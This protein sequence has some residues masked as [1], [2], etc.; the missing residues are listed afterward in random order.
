MKE[1]SVQKAFKMVTSRKDNKTSIKLPY[2]IKMRDDRKEKKINKFSLK[3]LFNAISLVNLKHPETEDCPEPIDTKLIES[4]YIFG[5]AVNPRYEKI[6]KKFAFGLYSYETERMVIPNDL[7]IICFMSEAYDVRHI[8]SMTTWEM[9]ISSSYGD[10]DERIYGNF[11]V[12][13]VPSSLVYYRYE[14]NK[15]FLENIKNDGVCIMGKNLLEAKRYAEWHH[16]TIKDKISCIITKEENIT[17]EM[18]KQKEQEDQKQNRWEML[19]I[20]E[21]KPNV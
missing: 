14:E 2:K 18:L 12:S 5:S 21:R 7:D 15:A 20:E 4:C 17:N 10:H 8:K 9:T 19:D 11:D 3:F 13:F 6:T 1:I 16:D